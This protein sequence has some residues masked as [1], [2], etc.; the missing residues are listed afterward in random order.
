MT[1]PF[2]DYY[3]AN[4]ISPVAQDITDLRK[5]FER[6]DSLY[7]SL[8]IPPRY[9]RGRDVLEFGPGSG[10][11]SI[12]TLG[13]QPRRY[14]LVD[15]NPR[16][17]KDTRALLGRMYPEDESFE[18]LE[19]L[20]EDFNTAE[21]F[22]L[23]AAEGLV[24]FQMEPDV[25][26][27]G[28]ARFVA[29][30]GILVLTCLDAATFLGEIGR[31]LIALRLEEPGASERERVERLTPIFA[32]HLA[33]LSGMSRSVEDWIYDNITIPI[34]GKTF[35]I[36]EAIAALGDEFEV[37]GSSPEFVLDL[38]WYKR[39]FG[40][41]RQFNARASGAYL[42]NILNFMDCRVTVPPNDP[43]L[44]I[45]ITN[46]CRAIWRE[47]QTIEANRTNRKPAELSPAIREVADLAGGS[48]RTARA[49]RELADVLEV[50]P[51]GDPNCHLD[52]FV[53]YFGRGLQHLSLVRRE[54]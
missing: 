51:L 27:R 7:R 15:G 9:V 50:E 23:V 45:A 43:E 30:Q 25:F 28:I 19:A 1:R 11:N 10:H 54:Q 31:R 16:G 4:D 33:T 40:D 36:D 18:V 44:G 5:H 35:G 52:E 32:P 47:M 46:K 24:P 39:L 8:R 42:S 41:E 3:R 26:I 49:L 6:R 34:V 14:L 20:I 12:H 48:P 13:L 38:R 21:R 17:V 29:D 2:I 53:S 22:D 37:Y